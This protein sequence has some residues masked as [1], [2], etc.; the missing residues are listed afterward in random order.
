MD[1][2]KFMVYA[3]DVKD[4]ITKLEAIKEDEVA[5]DMLLLGKPGDMWFLAQ[6]ITVEV[7]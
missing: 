6:D 4:A 1:E 2:Y 3:T 7:L 5:K